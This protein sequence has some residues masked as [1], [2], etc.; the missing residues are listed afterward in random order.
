METDRRRRG[1]FFL[2]YAQGLSS[3]AAA[4]AVRAGAPAVRAGAPARCPQ[5]G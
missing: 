1:R 3:R 2:S 5:R 4:P